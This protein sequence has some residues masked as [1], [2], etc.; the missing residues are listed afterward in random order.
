MKGSHRS[1]RRAFTRLR[2][3]TTHKSRVMIFADN[4]S[5]HRGILV[6]QFP[7]LLAAPGPR[8]RSFVGRVCST[9]DPARAEA[10]FT[11][12]DEDN[13]GDPA[14]VRYSRA[15]VQGIQLL[16]MRDARARETLR[17]S[18]ISLSFSLSS[19]L[20]KLLPAVFFF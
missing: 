16:R 18:L 4:P 3:A 20:Y 13:Y 2:A 6:S 7:P 8:G 15:I 17:K 14:L 19:I 11:T 5:V 9:I 12:H 10:L 1:I